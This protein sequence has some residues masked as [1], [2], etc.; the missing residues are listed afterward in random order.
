M[1]DRWPEQP[2]AYSLES[3]EGFSRPRTQQ[4]PVHRSPQENG[5][6]RTGS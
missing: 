2:E 4:M 3:D 5:Q 1:R 6:C